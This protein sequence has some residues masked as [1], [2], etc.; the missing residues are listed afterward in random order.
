MSPDKVNV[1]V[2]EAAKKEEQFAKRKE[3]IAKIRLK[4]K[5][6]E[7][8]LRDYINKIE[9]IEEIHI[10]RM[11]AKIDKINEKI[12]ELRRQEIEVRPRASEDTALNAA[13]R[14]HKKAKREKKIAHLKLKAAS[15][16]ERIKYYLTKKEFI[17][18]K[19]IGKIKDGIEKR[20]QLI[21][22]LQHAKHW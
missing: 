14:M 5:H 4:I 22:E 13:R 19:H 21:N 2:F 1:A 7:E 18:E 6:D 20:K 11:R 12:I 16:E 3:K 10:G 8:K 17:K 15:L 9:Y